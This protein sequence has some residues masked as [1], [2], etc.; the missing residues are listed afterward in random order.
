M[1]KLFL[2]LLAMMITVTM[3]FTVVSCG[4]GGTT[5]DTDD[6][7]DE[8]D[9]NTDDGNT[10]DGNTDDGNTDDG[11]TDDGNTDDGNTDDGNT[12]DGNT[13]DGNTDDGNT[14]DGN[15]DDGNTDDGNTDDGNTDDGNTDDG[16]TDDGNTDDG[17][18]GG[19]S[20][21]IFN[22]IGSSTDLDGEF[23]MDDPLFI[24]AGSGA[25]IYVAFD[26]EVELTG[27]RDLSGYFPDLKLNRTFEQDGRFI[28]EYTY[29]RFD[30]SY[31]HYTFFVDY[32]NTDGIDVS[33]LMNVYI[34]PDG[35]VVPEYLGPAE[36]MWEDEIEGELFVIGGPGS[37]TQLYYVFD[38]PVTPLMFYINGK[39]FNRGNVSK[40]GEKYILSMSASDNVSPGEYEVTGE[41]YYGPGLVGKLSQKV[42]V[43]AEPT[44]FGILRAGDTGLVKSVIS[45]NLGEE[46]KLVAKCNSFAELKSITDSEGNKISFTTEKDDSTLYV[47]F[48]YKASSEKGVDTITFEVEY[49]HGKEGKRTKTFTACI[50][51]G[52]SEPTVAG[53]VVDG[54]EPAKEITVTAGED[55]EAS[56]IF[57][58]E[59]DFDVSSVKIMFTSYD[60]K[61]LVMAEGKDGASFLLDALEIGKHTL[62]VYYHIGGVSRYTQLTIIAVEAKDDDGSGDDGSGEVDPPKDDGEDKPGSGDDPT[63]DKE[64]PPVETEAAFVGV[65]QEDGELAEK[66]EISVTDSTEIYIVFTTQ[67]KIVGITNNWGREDLV[68]YAE[69]KAFIDEYSGYYILPVTVSPLDT[70]GTTNIELTLIVDYA[71]GDQ[72]FTQDIGMIAYA[73]VAP[74]EVNVEPEFVGY[75][76]IDYNYDYVFDETAYLNPDTSVKVTVDQN[77]LFVIAFKGYVNAD[78]FLINGSKWDVYSNDTGSVPGMT[79]VYCGNTWTTV[80]EDTATL[81]YSYYSYESSSNI[82]N[83]ELVFN[84]SVVNY[85]DDTGIGDGE[86]IVVPDIPSDDYEEQIPAEFLGWYMGDGEPD[87]FNEINLK[88]FEENIVYLC[89]SKEVEFITFMINK[90][91]YKFEVVENNDERYVVS[92]VYYPEKLFMPG[93]VILYF[94]CK[95][96]ESF[97]NFEGLFSTHIEAL[98]EIVGVSEMAP[99]VIAGIENEVSFL[100]SQPIEITSLSYGEGS[101][102]L[103]FKFLGCE[104]SEE[105]GAYRCTVILYDDGSSSE[106][107]EQNLMIRYVY[108]GMES[109]D[110]LPN[111]FLVV[112]REMITMLSYYVDGVENADAVWEAGPYELVVVLTLS[113]EEVV[114]YGAVD[115]EILGEGG[116]YDE[117]YCGYVYSFTFGHDYAGDYSFMVVPRFNGSELQPAGFINIRVDY[118]PGMESM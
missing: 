42:T 108:L 37:S 72:I 91:E 6:K 35:K 58:S 111:L 92:F 89:F 33:Y 17:T 51:S 4:G 50:L 39:G 16:N 88:P 18:N 56:V 61:N 63:D 116:E 34:V 99:V 48:D 27:I 24:V 40:F 54:K 83:A 90:E 7:T 1:K 45:A 81:V 74:P 15:T 84:V 21:I 112:R 43:W 28:A 12:D 11:N 117:K 98:P 55:I 106:Y 82:E 20:D 80:G 25:P 85:D 52:V 38:A 69:E 94:E 71:V 57:N 87:P 53:I 36:K 110:M 70:D 76:V 19:G 75:Y 44:Y 77:A 46:L 104:Y 101:Y 62:T 31:L 79:I 49:L 68:G 60:F 26:A 115:G 109:G 23:T 9:G 3:M 66:V 97:I 118:F 86:D 8:D 107:Y 102:E 22:I 95:S 13:D 73:T 78:H 10:D 14:D 100:V 47:F 103:G 64:D 67:V 65:W 114:L 41:Y 29:D 96:G 5:G 113:A 59:I 30:D 105:D 2:A 93:E 32:K